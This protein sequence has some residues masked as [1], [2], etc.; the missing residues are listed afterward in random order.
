M[1]LSPQSTVA[2]SF[3]SEVELTLV[4]KI[5]E[6]GM[7]SVYEAVLHGPRGFEKTVAL[8]TI[9]ERYSTNEQFVELFIGEAKLVA[10]LVHQNICQVYQLGRV[11]QRYFIAMEYINGVNLRGFLRRHAEAGRRLPPELAVFITSRICR[12]L[13]YAHGKRDKRGLLLG[14][15]HRDVGPHNI[16]VSTEGEVK[17]TDFGVAKART[18]TADLEDGRVMVG[19]AEY[20][21]PEQVRMEPTDGRSDLFSLG[22]VMFE[23]LT[24]E[25]LFCAETA[26]EARRKVLELPF[27]AARALNPAVSEG[28]AAVLQRALERDPAA[29]Y[30]SAG[31]MGYELE[32]QIYHQGYGPTIVTLEKHMRELF[33]ELFGPRRPP[34]KPPGSVELLIGSTTPARPDATAKTV[35]E[36]K[37]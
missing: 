10:D 19:K 34:S 37:P 11:G 12:G 23:L 1:P 31:E 26:E 3:I 14:L 8:K 7:G 33:P 2:S 28:T 16:M 6:G 32:Y 18:Q 5:A 27:P 17:L 24:G 21:S 13:E 25:R 30:Q 22:V 36:R 15:V 4:R 20:M 9:V 35:L 29:R